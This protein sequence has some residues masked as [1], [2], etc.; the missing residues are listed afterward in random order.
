MG[1][2]HNTAVPVE[3]MGWKAE[4]RFETV[5]NYIG[6]DNIIRKGAISCKLGEKVLIP[7]N[8]AYGSFIAIGNGNVDWNNSGPHGAGRV[9]SRTKA[10]CLPPPPTLPLS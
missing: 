10:N 9:Y 5:H 7:I 8:M 3:E 2:F 6:E 1:Q 4:E